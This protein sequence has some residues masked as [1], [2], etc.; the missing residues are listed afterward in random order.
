MRLVSITL[1]ECHELLINAP[2]SVQ[3]LSRWGR[4]DNSNVKPTDYS[5][6]EGPRH[7]TSPFPYSEQVNSRFIVW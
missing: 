7:H 6:L 2:I 4:K 3:S 1:N 5:S